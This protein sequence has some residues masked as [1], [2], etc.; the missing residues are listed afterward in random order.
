MFDKI[1]VC[2]PL[3]RNG[4]LSLV[5]IHS[6]HFRQNS[7]EN[8]KIPDTIKNKLSNRNYFSSNR[9]NIDQIR[10]YYANFRAENRRLFRSAARRGAHFPTPDPP[11]FKIQNR[12][13]PKTTT[14]NLD[15]DRSDRHVQSPQLP[16][17]DWALPAHCSASDTSLM[18]V[19]Q[20]LCI[21]RRRPRNGLGFSF[22]DFPFFD[23]CVCAVS[24]IWIWRWCLKR[25]SIVRLV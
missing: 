22:G 10:Q 5:S 19:T 9:I 17:I 25:C 14:N 16:V 18:T 3:I 4:V 11:K 12:N 8:L 13:D 20:L 15:E 6:S 2:L 24:K 23:V 21:D 1:K 7:L